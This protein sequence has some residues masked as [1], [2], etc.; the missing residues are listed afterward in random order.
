[1]GSGAF[2]QRGLQRARSVQGSAPLG[3]PLPT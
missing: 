3:F 1:V 2:P